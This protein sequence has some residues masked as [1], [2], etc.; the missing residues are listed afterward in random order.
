MVYE[1]IYKNEDQ[2][3]FAYSTVGTLWAQ[4]P[5]AQV[6]FGNKWNFIALIKLSCLTDHM[7]ETKK[8]IWSLPGNIATEAKYIRA[9]QVE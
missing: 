8:Q 6:P 1:F 2:N 5:F 3:C 4:V 7:V 9:L